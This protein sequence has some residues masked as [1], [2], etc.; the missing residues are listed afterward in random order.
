MLVD[1]DSSRTHNHLYAIA[2]LNT[3]HYRIG[4]IGPLGLYKLR[5]NCPGVKLQGKAMSLCPHFALS[6]IFQQISQRLPC[7]KSIRPFHSV[8][9]DWLDLE[10]GW[11]TYQGNE[12]IVRRAIVVIC[13]AIGMVITYFTQSAKEDKNLSLLQDFVTWLALRYNLEVKIISLDNE[14]NQIKTKN[15]CNNVGIFFELCA[16]DT[17]AQNG[18]AECF[19]CPIMEKVRAMRLSTN[20]PHKL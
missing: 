13:D 10:E 5:K 18:S 17:H 2:S 9:I 4:H 7:N 6:K 16:L 8:F 11:D 15:W 14:M 19:G 3:L 12:A 1:K 20:L